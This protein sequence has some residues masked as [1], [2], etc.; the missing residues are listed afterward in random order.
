MA[1]NRVERT[2]LLDTVDKVRDFTSISTIT[3]LEIDLKQKRFII[4]GKSILGIFSCDLSKPLTLS[5]YNTNAKNVE[6]FLEAIEQFIV[7]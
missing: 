4:D 5:V 1:E 3:P 2:I 7:D 6:K